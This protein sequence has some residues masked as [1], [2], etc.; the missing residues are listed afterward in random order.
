M[1]QLKSLCAGAPQAQEDATPKRFVSKAFSATLRVLRL[2]SAKKARL[3]DN[4]LA[5]PQQAAVLGASPVLL[6]GDSRSSA[7]GT[8]DAPNPQGSCPA[9]NI[10]EDHVVACSLPCISGLAPLMLPNGGMN[11]HPDAI[12]SLVMFRRSIIKTDPVNDPVQLPEAC[13]DACALSA[14]LPSPTDYNAAY[15][16]NILD[17]AYV[18]VEVEVDNVD[19]PEALAAYEGLFQEDSAAELLR[20]T[21]AS[22]K[23]ATP[24]NAAK[25]DNVDPPKDRATFP[26]LF[27]EGNAAE[28]DNVDHPKDRATFP[29]LARYPCEIDPV[30][31]V[32]FG[33]ESFGLGS[34]GQ[35]VAEGPG[36]PMSHSYFQTVSS[37]QHHGSSVDAMYYLYSYGM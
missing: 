22:S 30:S 7:C 14:L 19:P 23:K 24:G 9:P 28:A 34:L 16:A 32:I 1:S 4:A 15:A 31:Y 2:K 37:S 20:P 29:G 11:P 12:E 17:S 21:R 18:E 6:Q 3:E 5:P 25:A 26:G 10:A 33:L 35:G 27:Q 13:T 36:A 8:N